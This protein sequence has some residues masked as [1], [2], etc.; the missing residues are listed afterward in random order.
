MTNTA[1]R[2]HSQLGAVADKAR[3]PSARVGAGLAPPS[4]HHP[5]G[6]QLLAPSSGTA[7]SWY[8]HRTAMSEGR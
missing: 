1:L 8:R 7:P 4:T 6:Q 2:R 5:A 3:Q